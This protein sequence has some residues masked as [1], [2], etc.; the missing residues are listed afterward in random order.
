MPFPASLSLANSSLIL[1]KVCLLGPSPYLFTCPVGTFLLLF[2]SGELDG[3]FHEV[4][5]YPQ[6]LAQCLAMLEGCM[7]GWMAG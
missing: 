4:F 6:C 5:Q 7:D 3:E 2:D 1:Q